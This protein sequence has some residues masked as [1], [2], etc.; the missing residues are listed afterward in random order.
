GEVV[1]DVK[2]SSQVIDV[3]A[4]LLDV[5]EVKLQ[6]NITGEPAGTYEVTNL[7]IPKTVKIRGEKSLLKEIEQV[8]S[9]PIN[10]SDVTS[11]AQIP[12]KVILPEGVE[13]A[14]G[15]KDLSMTIQ[16]KGITSKTFEYGAFEFVVEDLPEKMSV[17][18]D[19]P[20]IKMIVS[21]REAVMANVNK[22]DFV[23]HINLKGMTIGTAQ[24]KIIAVHEKQVGTVEIL[25]EVVE[26]TLSE[27]AE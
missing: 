27:V 17:S 21:G 26:I 4:K 2:L 22:S 20:S 1:P 16:L 24:A 23:P 14:N 5:K 11:D 13:L 3:T 9:Q 7:K 10:L 6:A 15:S 25:P 8:I 12:V 18:I 19:T